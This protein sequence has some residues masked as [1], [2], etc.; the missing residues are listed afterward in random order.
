[1]DLLIML[2][3]G[4]GVRL[5]GVLIVVVLASLGDN[6]QQDNQSDKL[7]ETALLWPANSQHTLLVQTLI[8][9]PTTTIAGFVWLIFRT[10]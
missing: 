2:V 10:Q 3:C 9:V 8:W 1:M 7:V 6:K 5:I 4:L